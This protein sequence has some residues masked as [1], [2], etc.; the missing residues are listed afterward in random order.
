M[1]SLSGIS[2]KGEFFP[3]LV[4]LC[5]VYPLKYK[6]TSLRHQNKHFSSSSGPLCFTNE[7]HTNF[8]ILYPQKKDGYLTPREV[9]G[10]GKSLQIVPMRAKANLKLQRNR[11]ES[12]C[13]LMLPTFANSFA[14][15]NHHGV[16][17]LPVQE[18]SRK[19]QSYSTH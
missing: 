2:K 7:N 15:S 4:H 12:L 11:T 16:Y 10:L 3:T 5:I 14:L 18:D 19:H 17:M 8:R 6:P 13:S 9:P 1:L